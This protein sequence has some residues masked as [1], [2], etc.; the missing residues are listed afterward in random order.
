MAKYEK[1]PTDEGKYQ[2]PI[3]DYG[4]G[5][6]NGKSRQAVSKHFKIH[7]SD[8]IEEA[9]IPES[10]NIKIEE[11][12]DSK[13]EWLSFDMSDESG[14]VETE[15]ISPLA[16]SFIKGMSKQELPTTQKE[17]RQFYQTQGKM[18]SWIFTGIIDPLISWYGRAITTN[19]D[20]KVSRSEGDVELLTD[21]S[22]QWLEYRQIQLPVTTD[23]IMGVTVASMYAP[24]M[25]KIHKK[26]DPNRPS[27]FKRWKM[28]RT[29]RKAMKQERMKKDA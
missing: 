6:G 21:S 1:H 28:R 19:P 11:N 24:V 16:S 4:H 23:I 14:E 12:D 18:M 10:L 3:C 17:L 25:Y 2:C 26:R 13:P 9:D 27:L 15:S 29:L 20:F 22:A 8:P 5:E 7:T